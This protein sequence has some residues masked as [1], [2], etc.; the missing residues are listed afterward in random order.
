MPQ[1]SKSIADRAAAEPVWEIARI[2]PNQ[3]VWDERD[4]LG[5]ETNHLIEF[6]DGY[7]EVLPMPK[8]SHQLIVQY[9][10]NVLLGFVTA[11][12]LG[13]V[14]FAPL[15]VRLRKAKY[16]EP[17][18][19][20]MLAGHAA[21]IRE[22]YWEGADLVMEV[23]SDEPEDRERDLV[24]KRAEYAKAGIPEY[25]IVDPYERRIRVLKLKAS[26]YVVHGEFGD[27]DRA[28][29]ARLAGFGVEVAAV[30]AAGRVRGKAV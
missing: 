17:D 26:R 15:R 3:G 22:E 5:I 9:L 19:V 29:S 1:M 10:S 14:L 30:W 13:T 28:T 18:V 16:R 7:V 21:R 4:Y 25:W 24:T 23:V 6:S 2:Y 20:F 11:G 27:K 8:T 12:R